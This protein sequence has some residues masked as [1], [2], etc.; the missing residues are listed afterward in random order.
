MTTVEDVRAFID[1]LP[2]DALVLPDWHKGPPGDDSP[3]VEICGVTIGTD[4]EGA[5]YLSV[6]VG[7]IFLG[8]DSEGRN[9][10]GS[11]RSVEISDI[12]FGGA[13]TPIDTRRDDDDQET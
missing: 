5:R 6:R 13:T 8:E 4:A 2:A 12:I 9:L 1:Q 10:E 11:I 3:A 7:L